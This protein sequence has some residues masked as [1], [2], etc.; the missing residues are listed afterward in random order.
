[1]PTKIT[2]LPD[3]PPV[4]VLD[5]PFDSALSER[6]LVYALSTITARSLPDVRDGLKPVHRRLLWA[7]RLLRLDPAAGYKKC[8]RVVGD[9]IGKYHP[10][11]DQSVY[12]AMVR[13]AQDFALRYPL[14]DG[15]GNFGNIDG[16]NAAAYRYTE[17]RLTQVAIDLMDGLDEDAVEF[18]PTYNGEEQEPELFP[19]AF[20]NLLANGAAGIAV[21]MA[22]AIPPH[23]AAELLDAAIMLVD[24]PDA[25]DAD[26]LALVKGPDF[27]TG[28]LV[29]DPPAAIT[30]AYVTG[31][32]A[33]RVRARW[34]IEREKGGGWQIVVSEI[35]YGVPKGKLIEQIAGLINDKKL[36]ILADVR[37]E[38]DAE[39][40][41]VLEPRSRTVDA[42][43]LMDGLF[44]LSDLESRIPLNLNVLDRERTPRVMSLRDALAAWVEH[45]FVVLRR[46]TEHRLG[47]IADRLE[48]VGGYIVAFLNL[49]RVI[50]IIR[51][52]DEPKAVMI[53]EFQLTDRQA[54]AILNMRLRSLR[55]LEEMELKREQATLEKEQADLTLLLGSEARQR[56]RLKRDFGRVRAR[57]GPETPLGARRT[58]IEEAAPTRDIPLEAMIEREPITVILSERGW[59]RALKG[60]VDL[61]APETLKFKEGDGPAFAFHA[62]TTDKLLLAAANGR[63]YTLAADKL[64]GGRGFG[65]PVRATIDLDGSVPIV[66]FLPLRKA[67]RLLLA[68]SDGRGFVVAGADTVAETRKG[69]NV[70]SPRTGARLAV[71]HPVAGEDDYVAVIGD[72]RKM[73]VFPIAELPALAR[74][75]GVQLQRYREGGLADAKT[76]VFA[77]GLSWTMG[78]ETGRTRTEADLNPWR[79][80]RGAAG[81]M[82]PNGFPRDNRF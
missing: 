68:A 52:E 41:L 48:L 57:Y 27:P 34:S 66:A 50:E 9:V 2:D 73:L 39:V 36:P 47:K 37:D 55:R 32:G 15:Q 13:L 12:D 14:V 43:V 46:R 60:H 82:P 26:V 22:T 28:G 70:M 16:D 79:T 42:Q 31:R 30:E 38:S 67:E 76:F 81:R 53:A 80:A 21:G 8:A 25:G 24:R 62:Q 58:G 29:V 75:Q 20:P 65:E 35:P 44:R 69:K 77:Q 4:G 19:G 18:R 72:N 54:E 3:N 10:H 78:G 11:G 7:M 1:M 6:Y 51:T 61:S 33:F 63:F 5:A 64:P 23:N 74:G 49:D 17:A 40:R 56:T 71:V 59:V 45:Q